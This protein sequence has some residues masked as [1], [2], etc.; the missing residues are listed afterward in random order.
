[1]PQGSI[2]GP[3]LFLV[4]VNDFQYACNNANPKLFADDSNLC[5]TGRNL[6]ELYEAANQAC[7]QVSHWFKCNRLTVNYSKSV[8]LLF[9][10]HKDDDDYISSNNL[11]IS[12]DNNLIK[13]VNVT[14]FLGV[15]IDEK[16][17]YEKHVNSIVCKINSLNGML[18]RRRDYIP[19]NCRRNLFFALVQPCIQYG[20]EIYGKTTLNVLQPLH[21]SCNRVLRTLQGQSRFC[22]VMQLY[23]NYNILPVHQLYTFSVCKMIY[24]CLNYDGLMSAAIKDIFKPLQS[25]HWCNTRLSNTNYIY[26]RF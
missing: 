14:K 8:Y 12:L 2:L 4:Y 5:V 11:C 6:N 20:I 19:M 9:F 1:M 16:L 21:V 10:P 18:Y 17:A 22:N 24:K 15:L 13:R 26:S 25:N 3:L 7:S 23:R